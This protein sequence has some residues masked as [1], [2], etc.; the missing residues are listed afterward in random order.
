MRVAQRMTSWDRHQDILYHP[1]WNIIVLQLRCAQL[2]TNKR[3]ADQKKTPADWWFYYEIYHVIIYK[4]TCH[5]KNIKWPQNLPTL[6]DC[7]QLCCLISFD[8]KQYNKNHLI[9][10]HHFFLLQENGRTSWY[11][12]NWFWSKCYH[13]KFQFKSCF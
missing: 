4:M 11:R 12:G 1:A 8:F 6:A 9:L 5:F 10:S 2:R 3:F 7:V 13:R